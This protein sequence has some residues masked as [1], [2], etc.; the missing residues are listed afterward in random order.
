MRLAILGVERE[1]L[2]LARWAVEAGGHECVVAYGAGEQAREL[3]SIAAGIR[4]SE[5]WE[6]LLS[7]ADID[8]V[9]VASANTLSTSDAFDSFAQRGEQLRRLVQERVP[10]LVVCPACEAIV[11]FEIEMIRRDLG[12]VIV[13]CVPGASHVA[14]SQL[15][16]Y[17]A[18]GESGPLGEVQ[19]IMLVRELS[20]RGREAVMHQLVRD[21]AILRHLIGSIQAV[22]ASGPA[23]AIGRDPLGPKPESLPSLN[24]LSVIL[25]GDRELTARWLLMPTSGDVQGELIVAGQRYKSVLTMAAATSLSLELPGDEF[26]VQSFAGDIDLERMFDQLSRALQPHP[27]HDESAWL[28]ACRD[29][30]VAEAVDRSLARGRTIELFHE[31]HTEAA[32]FKGVMAMGGCLLLLLALC[33]LLLVSVVDGLRLPLRNLQAWRLWPLYLLIPIGAFLLLQLLGL[34]AKPQSPEVQPTTGR[35]DG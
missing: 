30:E 5:N 20:D 1:I 24:N 18:Q 26:H 21:V 13:P 35:R 23:R 10:M 9:L 8:A 17:V 12:S 22:T 25:T 29:Q 3:A 6:E 16:A 4:L 28:E 34:V 7:A 33:A 2:R 32:S 14:I 31:E 15:A 27:A 19:Q 11:G